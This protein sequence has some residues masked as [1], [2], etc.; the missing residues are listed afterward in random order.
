ME[1]QIME[2]CE[3]SADRLREE[4]DHAKAK[5][6]ELHKQIA[7]ES[8]PSQWEQ[9][10]AIRRLSQLGLALHSLGKAYSAMSSGRC[11]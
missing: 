7:E 5:Y 11:N 6:W 2:I 3:S 4:L 9:L 10:D 1:K 8:F